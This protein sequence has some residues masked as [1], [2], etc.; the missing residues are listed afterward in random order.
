M[1]PI[2]LYCHALK[3]NFPF[4]I[5]CEA[6]YHMLWEHAA[7]GITNVYRTHTK[8]GETKINYLEM[9]DGKVYVVETDDF[10]RNN[11]AHDAGSLY[12]SST[13]GGEHPLN[14]CGDH[15]M[16]MPARMIG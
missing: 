12:P 13:F 11:A 8:V 14:T 2:K 9:K 7:G 15:R 6:V 4:T 16:R 5:D 10:V 1:L 3:N